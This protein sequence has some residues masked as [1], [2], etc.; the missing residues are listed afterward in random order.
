M[1]V[2]YK[3]HKLC[4]PDQVHNYMMVE[5]YMCFKND[6]QDE[7]IVGYIYNAIKS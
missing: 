6:E 1:K 4:E 3:N 2:N 7:K 5:I